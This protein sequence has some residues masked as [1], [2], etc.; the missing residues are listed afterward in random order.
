MKKALK[1][2]LIV[3]L[4]AAVLVAVVFGI[5]IAY[6][7]YIDSTYVLDYEEEVKSASEKYNVPQ[8]LIYGV[9]KTESSFN[10]KAVSSAGARGLMQITPDTFEWLN[11][12][13]ADD[14]LDGKNPELLFKEEINIEYGTLLLSIL[15]DRY[16][17]VDTAICAYNAGL[18]N[19]DGWLEDTRYSKDGKTLE[20]TPF[21]ETNNYLVRVKKN[22]DKYKEKFFSN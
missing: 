12:Y 10:P 8:E 1:V 20:T 19:V 2:T 15:I 5:K 14:K 9:I 17:D 11:L 16:G 7:Q 4:S 6:D 21:E 13:Y 22:R 3:V 18:G